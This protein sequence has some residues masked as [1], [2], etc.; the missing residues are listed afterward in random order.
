MSKMKIISFLWPTLYVIISSEN[1]LFKNLYCYNITTLLNKNIIHYYN[2]ASNEPRTKSINLTL[3]VVCPLQRGV[4]RQISAT[5]PR[6]TCSSFG[7]T[8]EKMMRPELEHMM[9]IYLIYILTYIIKYIYYFIIYP[10]L[11]SFLEIPS[12]QVSL[13]GEIVVM[14]KTDPVRLAAF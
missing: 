9:H 2:K 4:S 5:L 8:F 6:R 1:K 13:C 10:R 11:G 14:V 12:T 7:A 3:P